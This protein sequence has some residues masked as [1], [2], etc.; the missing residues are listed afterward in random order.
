M[1]KGKLDVKRLGLS[2][3]ITFGA[4]MF[5]LGLVSM[6]GY[7][8]EI[9]RLI[10]TAYVGFNSTFLGSIIGGIYGF[11]DGLVGGALIAWIYNKL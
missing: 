2:F 3:G 7:G 11:I 8:S 1:A 5:I 10:G 6:G 9:V 4:G